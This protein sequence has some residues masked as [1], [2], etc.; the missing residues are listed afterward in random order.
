MC[1]EVEVVDVP[2]NYNLLLGRSCTYA[3]HVVVD[4]VFQ[5]FLFPHEGQI[6]TV[7]QLAF[8]CPDPSLGASPVPMV[9]SPQLDIINIG[10]GLCPPMMGTFN[11]PP[12]SSDVNFILAVPD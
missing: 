10:V 8:S 11:Y 5:V 9:D 2:L 3:M 7:D 12:P 1:I 6:L 4:T